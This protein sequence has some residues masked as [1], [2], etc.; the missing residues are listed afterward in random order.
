MRLPFIKSWPSAAALLLLLSGLQPCVAEAPASA[1]VPPSPA[2][3]PPPA[4]PK[5]PLPTPIWPTP[6]ATAIRYI[7]DNSLPTTFPAPESY[8]KRKLTAGDEATLLL[9]YVDG[10]KTRQYVIT[11]TVE[12]PTADEKKSIAEQPFVI[13]SNT[14]NRFDY[15]MRPV[16]LSV[17][18]IGPFTKSEGRPRV[19]TTRLVANEEHLAQGFDG[20]CK[21]YARLQSI[22]Q[23]KENAAFNLRT[24]PYSPEEIAAAQTS[25]ARAGL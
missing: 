4:T 10:W 16:A 24:S 17:S 9:S 25:F 8:P 19:R 12:S 20:A 2:D 7:C 6:N 11:I 13:F 1:P 18:M 21:A 14:G 15:G 22:K 23:N 3:V 5:V